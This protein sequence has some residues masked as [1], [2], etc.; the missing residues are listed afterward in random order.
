MAKDDDAKLLATGE[1]DNEWAAEIKEALEARQQ[2]EKRNEQNPRPEPP[3]ALM[4]RRQLDNG[5]HAKARCTT[6]TMRTGTTAKS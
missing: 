1:G 3:R 6:H 2:T 5:T 4:Q